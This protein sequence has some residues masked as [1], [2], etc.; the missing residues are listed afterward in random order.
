MTLRTGKNG[1]YRYYA[2]SIKA[3]QGEDRL[4]GPGDPD[5]HRGLLPFHDNGLKKT[6]AR[7]FY[8]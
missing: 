8:R 3:R 1:R 5:G 7:P 4:Q 6:P 2:C